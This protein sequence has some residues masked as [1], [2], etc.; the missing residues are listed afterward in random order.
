M[1]PNFQYCPNCG[2]KRIESKESLKEL[3]SNFLGDYFTYDSKLMSSLR[4]LI[5][6]PGFLTRAYIEGKRRGYIAPLRLYI[7]ISIVFF[8]VLN[9]GAQSSGETEAA[10]EWDSFFNNFMPKIF[11]LLVPL[12]ALLSTLL[13]RKDRLGFVIQM[14]GALHYHAFIFLILIIYLLV[15][16][17]LAWLGAY[18]INTVLL[19]AIGLWFLVYLFQACKRLS[20]FRGWSLVWRYMLLWLIY[21]GG[22]LAVTLIVFAAFTMSLS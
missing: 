14:V 20:S 7:F 15:S 4:P 17:L 16:K 13:F 21:V 11:F 2:Q 18:T 10:Q 9:F 12:F 19:G 3:G 1:K 6:K 22:V 8:L 5:G